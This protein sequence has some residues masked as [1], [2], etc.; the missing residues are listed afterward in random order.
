MCTP[1]PPPLPCSWDWRFNL[2]QQPPGLSLEAICQTAALITALWKHWKQSKFTPLYPLESLTSSSLSLVASSERRL[3]PASVFV[4]RAET[5]RQPV[6]PTLSASDINFFFL[7]L[8]SL[9]CLRRSSRAPRQTRHQPASWVIR[10]QVD[11]SKYVSSHLASPLDVRVHISIIFLLQRP[12]ALLFLTGGRQEFTCSSWFAGNSQKK[13]SKR[14][15]PGQFFCV[16]QTNQ[17]NQGVWHTSNTCL[18]SNLSGMVDKVV[19]CNLDVMC[20]RVRTAV[21]VFLYNGPGYAAFGCF[22]IWT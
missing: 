11:S 14:Y 19:L 9:V 13:K 17:I 8:W 3:L 15:G 4:S 16:Y 6:T 18:S 22:H 10:S 12:N 20:V 5:P 2:L 7:L 21:E 1:P